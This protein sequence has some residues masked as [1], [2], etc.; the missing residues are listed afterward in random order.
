VGRYLDLL[1]RRAS[2]RSISSLSAR[3][4]RPAAPAPTRG[5]RPGRLPDRSGDQ[6]WHA[7]F[8]RRLDARAQALLDEGV[9][10]GHPQGE[11]VEVGCVR[12]PAASAVRP[13]LRHRPLYQASAGRADVDVEAVYPEA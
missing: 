4:A 6:L 5:A 8:A 7:R 1:G 11:L 12:P 9:D 13:P 10:D 2:Q 3:S